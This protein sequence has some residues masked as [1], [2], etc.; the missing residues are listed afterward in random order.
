MHEA[1]P[2][3]VFRPARVGNAVTPMQADHASHWI[4]NSP[5][6]VHWAPSSGLR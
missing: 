6:L 5:L 1:R 2:S 4:L 3:P